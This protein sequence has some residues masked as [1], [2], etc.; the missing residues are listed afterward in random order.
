MAA[1]LVFCRIAAVLGTMKCLY[2]A[3]HRVG[4]WSLNKLRSGGKAAEK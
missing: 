4:R 1:E 2:W 3:H